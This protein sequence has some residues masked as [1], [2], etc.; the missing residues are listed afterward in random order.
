MAGAERGMKTAFLSPL[1]ERPLPPSLSR[2]ATGF[3]GTVVVGGRHRGGL[4]R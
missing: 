3:L 2:L 4:G 1:A